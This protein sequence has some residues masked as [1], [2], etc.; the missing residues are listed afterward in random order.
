MNTTAA[1]TKL[2]I[3]PWLAAWTLASALGLVVGLMTAP[4][5]W[6]LPES[7]ISAM[8][9]W[10]AAGIAGAII[11]LGVGAALGLAQGIV[12][13]ARGYASQRWFLATLVGGALG[14]ILAIALAEFNSNGE[15]TI[16]TLLSL[17]ALGMCIGTAQYLGARGVVKNAVWVLAAAVGIGLGAGLAFGLGNLEFI[18]LALGGLVYGGVTAATLWWYTK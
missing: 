6:S 13:R 1:Q 8:P 2:G 14:G 3:Y 9:E 11:G 10:L 7:I 4:L 5:L 12:L 17:G 18:R 15:N 16:V